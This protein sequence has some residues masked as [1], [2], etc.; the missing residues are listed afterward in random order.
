M[1]WVVATAM[2]T[3]LATFLTAVIGAIVAVKALK[4]NKNTLVL[5]ESTHKIVNQQ[6]TDM[7]QFQGVLINT[8]L[9]HGIEIPRNKATESP[10]DTVPRE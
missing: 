3:A 10:T 8:L 7:L 1:D 2:I 6:R 5:N 4:V 9:S